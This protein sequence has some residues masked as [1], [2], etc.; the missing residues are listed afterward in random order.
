MD[1]FLTHVLPHQSTIGGVRLSVP[2][3]RVIGSSAIL[4]IGENS[5]RGLSGNYSI[6]F[7]F[8]TAFTYKSAFKCIG[9]RPV[10]SSS[11]GPRIHIS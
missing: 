8:Q 1:N 6:N 11:Y 3:S 5:D 10:A 2:D 4:A 9:P 7:H